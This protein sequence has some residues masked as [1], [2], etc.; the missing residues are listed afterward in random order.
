MS[1]ATQSYDQIVEQRRALRIPPYFTLADVGFDGPWITPYQKTSRSP[2]GPVLV[3]LHWLDAPSI[4]QNRPILNELGYL[5]G[6]RFNNVLDLALKARRLTRKDIYVTQVFQL[7][8]RTRSQRIPPVSPPR[9]HCVR[10]TPTR[11]SP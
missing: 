10:W 9:I 11:Q 5:P 4:E 2:D 1:A 8:P 6:I 7:I 3:A